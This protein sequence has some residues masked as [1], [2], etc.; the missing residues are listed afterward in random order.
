MQIVAWDL[1]CSSL[2]GMMGRILCSG[3]KEILPPQHAKRI[4]PYMFRLDDERFA[5]DDV[6][7]DLKLATAI[8]DELE[9]YDII[10]AHNGI[11]FDRKFLNARL[12]KLYS[13]ERLCIRECPIP[14]VV[15]ICK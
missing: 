6:I 2:S 13:I 7:N 4:K 9:S 8:R 15:A 11:L 10:V 14:Y 5:T 3:F 12:M 1:E